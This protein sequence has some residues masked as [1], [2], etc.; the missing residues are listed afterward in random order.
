M[1][2]NDMT[3]ICKKCGYLYINHKESGSAP[4]NFA[5]NKFEEEERCEKVLNLVLTSNPPQYKC[6]YCFNSWFCDK[7]PPICKKHKNHSS[8]LADDKSVLGENTPEGNSNDIGVSPPSGTFNLS[9]K[10]II[11]HKGSSTDNC[12]FEEDVRTFIKKLK[13]RGLQR[14][15][16]PKYLMLTNDDLKELAGEEL[17]K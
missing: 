16:Y 11:T 5:C 14:T 3:K 6:K 13:E 12:Y 2:E 1:R 4:S 15:I 10:K 8:K 7:K 17:S 9:E